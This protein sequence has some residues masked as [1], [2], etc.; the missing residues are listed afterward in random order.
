MRYRSL[1]TLLSLL[2]TTVAR[3]DDSDK[4]LEIHG[5]VVD[6]EGRPVD[7][8]DAA[9][10][11]SS[12]GKL[13]NDAGKLG[14]VDKHPNQEGELA[15]YPMSLA[16]RLPE[17]KFSLT[18]HD[19]PRVT[20]YAVDKERKHGGYAT[21]EKSDAASE[22]TIK[23]VPLVRVHGKI[24]CADADVTPERTNASIRPVGDRDNFLKFTQCPSNRGQ[25]AFLLPP[26]KYDL[27]ISSSSPDARM[28]KPHERKDKDAPADM[29][30]WLSGIRIDVPAQG[31]LDLGTL[32]VDLPRDKDG[33]LHSYYLFYGKEP[34]ALS[35]TDARGVPKEVKLSDFRGKW[36]LLDFWA[37]WC[38]PCSYR[39]LPELTKFYEEHA[40]DRDRFEILAICNTQE[41]KA[42]TFEAYD[43]LAAPIVKD[44]WKGKELPF[45]ILLDG[46]GKT[47]VEYGI[48]A[49]PTTLLI[50]PEGHLVKG[51]NEAMLAEKLAEKNEQK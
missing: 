46:E 31:D 47:S 27:D 26:G 22:I 45:P 39:S 51:G 18:S 5:Q 33:V 50:D 17:G 41:E 19:R 2:L 28:P 20:I 30:P 15:P 40:A 14:P 1:L 48:R 43:P 4:P 21:I 6:E 10:F 11:W 35:I 25:F 12:S 38:T 44:V 24:Y 13:W 42:L 29:P 32:N 7:D 36:V 8:F 49:W 23:L 37:L 3:A 9:S 16:K 34:P